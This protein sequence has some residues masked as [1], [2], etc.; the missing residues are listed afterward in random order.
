MNDTIEKIVS[1]EWAKCAQK[2]GMNHVIKRF[3]Y[4]KD[5]WQSHYTNLS[6]KWE[7]ILLSSDFH[8]FKTI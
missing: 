1:K 6:T 4:T 3:E 8:P 7:A 5:V 2:H